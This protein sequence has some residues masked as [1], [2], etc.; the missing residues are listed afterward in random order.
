L[1]EHFAWLFNLPYK[2]MWDCI[3]G[4][5]MKFSAKTWGKLCIS[6]SNVFSC[7]F[8]RKIDHCLQCVFFYILLCVTASIMNCRKTHTAGNGQ[9]FWWKH[10]RKHLWLCFM[11]C[12]LSVSRGHQYTYMSCSIVVLSF[13]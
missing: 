12:V 10:R 5:F 6:H 13:Q 4:S 8:I 1:A 9:C 2:N 7:V 11:F 3:L